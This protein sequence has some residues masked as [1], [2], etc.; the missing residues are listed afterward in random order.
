MFHVNVLKN[1]KENTSHQKLAFLPIKSHGEYF[2]TKVMLELSCQEC[3]V[4]KFSFY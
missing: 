2:I 1:R 4:T 3:F